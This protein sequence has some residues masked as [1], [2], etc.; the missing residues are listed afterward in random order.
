MIDATRLPSYQG[1]R[2][3]KLT[4]AQLLNAYIDAYELLVSYQKLFKLLEETAKRM[5][6][7][8]LAK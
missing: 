7:R 5:H 1:I 8:V 2:A 4:P 6:T 3:D